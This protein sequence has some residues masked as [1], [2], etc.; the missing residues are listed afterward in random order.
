MVL[1]VEMESTCTRTVMFIKEDFLMIKRMD[2]VRTLTLFQVKNTMVIG[3]MGK[4]KAM[5]N[6]FFQLET[7]MTANSSKVKKMEMV[8]LITKVEETLQANGLMILPVEM[9]T[10]SFLMETVSMDNF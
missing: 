6:S 10:K 4:R 2:W 3:L 8:Q 9:E 7:S 1:K 5:E